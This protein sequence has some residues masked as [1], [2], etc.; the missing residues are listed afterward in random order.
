MF[1][2]PEAHASSVCND[3]QWLYSAHL[4]GTSPNSPKPDGLQIAFDTEKN[5][6]E[7]SLIPGVTFTGQ[8]GDLYEFDV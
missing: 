5:E 1:T 7:W 6:M 2:P 4:S 3:A 8:E